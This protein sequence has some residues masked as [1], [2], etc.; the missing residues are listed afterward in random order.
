MTPMKLRVHV[1]AINGNIEF[2]LSAALQ[3]KADKIHLLA[4]E[5]RS[6]ENDAGLIERITKSCNSKN[7]E[8]QVHYHDKTDVPKII[9]LGRDIILLEREND[10]YIN[11]SSGN[12]AQIVGLAHAAGSFNDGGNVQV[13]SYEPVKT[14]KS[15]KTPDKFQTRILDIPKIP[16]P[17]R[18]QRLALVE[19][20]KEKKIS[21][22]KLADILKL[23]NIITPNPGP[24]NALQVSVTNMNSNII[25][26][27]EKK[28]FIKQTKVGRKHIIEPTSQGI[29]ASVYFGETMSVPMMQSNL[30]SLHGRIRN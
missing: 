30:G 28:G 20:V 10:I 29:D 6:Q 22:S 25:Q 4:G 13:Y 5:N 9:K 11:I 1:I 18:N 3:S 19:I 17:D 8:T 12:A 2:S 21:K 23:R 7:I 26:P 27:L 14:N 16:L 24:G 15:C